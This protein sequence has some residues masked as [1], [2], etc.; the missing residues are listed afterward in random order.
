MALN[1]EV[2]SQERKLFELDDATMVIAPGSDGILGIL[3]NHSP[4]LTTL[5]NGELIIRR[6]G[7]EESFAIFGGFLEVRPDKVIVLADAADFSSDINLKEMEEARDRVK[8]MM[9]Q[10]LPPEQQA[11]VEAEYRRAELSINI[12]RKNQSRAGSVRIRVVEDKPN[13]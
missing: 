9:A 12:A 10:G 11:L 5:A 3:P 1:V 4:L 13:P 8:A 7:A 6:G 2:L